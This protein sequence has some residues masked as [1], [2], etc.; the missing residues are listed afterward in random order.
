MQ[1]QQ[2]KQSH[3]LSLTICTISQEKGETEQD[4]I[5]GRARMVPGVTLVWFEEKQLMENVGP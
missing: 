3:Q 2:K 5:L 4:K 1:G